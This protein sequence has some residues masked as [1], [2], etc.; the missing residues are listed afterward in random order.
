MGLAKTFS[1]AS[2][3]HLNGAYYRVETVSGSKARLL[4]TVSIYA[5]LAHCRNALPPVSSF[6]ISFVPSGDLRW[7][8]QAYAHL[9]TLPEFAG[10]VDC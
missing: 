5:S 3:I 4:A 2:G 9:K 6:D 1:S 10:A 8:A 7:D